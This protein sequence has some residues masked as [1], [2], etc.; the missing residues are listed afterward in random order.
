MREIAAALALA[1]AACGPSAAGPRGPSPRPVPRDARES[2]PRAERTPGRPYAATPITAVADELT[3]LALAL[4]EGRPAPATRVPLRSPLAAATQ[5]VFHTDAPAGATM[6]IGIAFELELILKRGEPDDDAEPAQRWGSLRLTLAL[7]RNGLRLYSVRPRTMSRALPGGPLPAG[8]EGF[9][10]VAADLLA[11]LRAGDVSAY[12]LDEADRALL[13]N[14]EVWIQVQQDRVAP[15][16]VT[17]VR[18][19]LATLPDAPLAYRLDDVAILVAAPEARLL[20]YAM[21]FE[22]EGD[23]FVL[24]TEPLVEVRQLWPR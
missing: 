14:D 8:M 3:E 16:L 22:P 2:P 19:M 5:A 13:G 10:T 11:A 6:V 24:A 4:A 20:S 12:A 18:A 9:A 15:E 21:S 7:S 23:R 1:L 17:D